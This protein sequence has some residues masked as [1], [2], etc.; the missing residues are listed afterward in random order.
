MPIGQY[1][2]GVSIDGGYTIYWSDCIDKDYQGVDEN[3]V[4]NLTVYPNPANEFI[5]VETNCELQR[6]DVYDVTGKL[7]I[8]STETE[9]NV[10][11]LES[12]IYFV[13]ILTDKGCV[14]KKISVVR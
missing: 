1:K 3:I 11:D 6:I 9:I 2:Y 5:H 4:D 7:M 12:G 8:S 14:T 10:S 13:N